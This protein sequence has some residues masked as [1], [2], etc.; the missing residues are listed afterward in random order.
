MVGT[1]VM[2]RIDLLL[3]R[4]HTVQVYGGTTKKSL[5]QLIII[6]LVL[7]C[8]SRFAYRNGLLG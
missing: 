3:P 2:D 8:A 5:L 6:R 4:H 7:A 1:F